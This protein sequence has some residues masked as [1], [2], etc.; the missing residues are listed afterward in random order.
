M[1]RSVIDEASIARLIRDAGAAVEVVAA[2]LPF[3]AGDTTPMANLVREHQAIGIPPGG[4]VEA[5]SA[6]AN[7]AGWCNDQVYPF[8]VTASQ[9]DRQSQLDDALAALDARCIRALVEGRLAVAVALRPMC[10]MAEPRASTNLSSSA[11][12]PFPGIPTL[13]LVGDQD[14]A[15]ASAATLEGRFP[16]GTT[17][18]VP[19]A[20]H[21]SMSLGVCIAAFEAQFIE[22]LEVPDTPPCGDR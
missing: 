6:G 4:D 18:V 12:H 20:Q 8:D 14:P 15:L 22:T 19:G 1:A 10:W 2:S 9:A 5:F 13:L 11:I 17:V 21:P 7:A 16:A 3:L